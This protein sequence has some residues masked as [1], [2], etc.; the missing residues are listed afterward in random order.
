MQVRSVNFTTS[1]EKNIQMRIR[2]T[3]VETWKK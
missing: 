1:Q 2:V 3:R